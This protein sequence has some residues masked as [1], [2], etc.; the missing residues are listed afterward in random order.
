MPGCSIV[1]LPT[2]RRTNI[3]S[4][5]TSLSSRFFR[6]SGHVWCRLPTSSMVSTR[7]LRRFLKPA[8]VRFDNNNY[9]GASRAIGRPVPAPSHR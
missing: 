1:A 4:S 7:P 9:S 5:P 8:P 3:L 2:P 6:L